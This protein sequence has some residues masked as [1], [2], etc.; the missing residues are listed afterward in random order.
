ML[1]MCVS[2]LR[3]PPPPGRWSRSAPP[4][5]EWQDW[6]RHSSVCVQL[7]SWACGPAAGAAL[8]SAAAV[9]VCVGGSCGWPCG[10]AGV[11]AGVWAVGPLHLTDAAPSQ[12]SPRRLQVANRTLMS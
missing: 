1:S 2:L 11:F 8:G 6:L 4:Q 10:S 3:L 5:E 12:R 7:P 9:A